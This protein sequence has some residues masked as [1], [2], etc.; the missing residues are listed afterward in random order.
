MCSSQLCLYAVLCL[1]HI[2]RLATCFHHWVSR[3][4]T[5]PFSHLP[6]LHLYLQWTSLWSL[7][8]SSV[9]TSSP[10]A[11]HEKPVI[12]KAAP[13]SQRTKVPL[14]S[15][16]KAPSTAA[17]GSTDALTMQSE[18][19]PLFKRPQELEQE[20]TKF[21]TDRPAQG[22]TL[23]G[24][25]E[26]PWDFG[27]STW[28]GRSRAL[29]IPLPRSTVTV[30]IE[31][32]GMPPTASHHPWEHGF[33]VW[34]SIHFTSLPSNVWHLCHWPPGLRSVPRT[35]RRHLPCVWWQKETC[36]TNLPQWRRFA[37]PMLYFHMWPLLWSTSRQSSRSGVPMA[38]GT[39]FPLAP[40]WTLDNMPIDDDWERVMYRELW[41][42]FTIRAVAPLRSF[43]THLSCLDLLF[44]YTLLYLAL[45]RLDL[46][47]VACSELV[48]SW[49]CTFTSYILLSG[50]LSD[51]LFTSALALQF[52]V[53]CDS[54][55]HLHHCLATPYPAHFTLSTSGGLG[56]VSLL[57]AGAGLAW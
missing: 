44:G 22:F 16:S 15:T 35:G 2:H 9:S 39:T 7:L 32:S 40:T 36:E 48:F 47:V 19:E 5:L 57:Q 20:G 21:Q 52:L 55:A 49:P 50:L 38:D 45:P 46:I 29:R 13:G 51:L 24:L 25:A 23:N 34:K 33:Y 4:V 56:C 8:L 17:S 30:V 18:D 42:P 1:Q 26:S 31:S 14:P 53:S 12:L 3:R 37:I 41:F 54:T 28:R 11:E 27:Q 6:P 10:A 43:T